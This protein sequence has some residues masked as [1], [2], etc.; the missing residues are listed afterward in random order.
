MTRTSRTV[1][2]L[3][4]LATALSVVAP[5]AW[6][7]DYWEELAWQVRPLVLVDG[8]GSADDWA[9]R[10][11]AARCAM[12]ERRIHWL[13]IGAD[14][15]VWRR[16]GGTDEAQ[17][18]RTRLDESAAGDVR[19]QVGWSAGDKTALVLFGLDGQE[20]YRGRPDSLETIWSLIDRMPMRRA[21]MAREPD[22]CAD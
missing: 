14:G 21:E 1:P 8:D 22:D 18:E 11:L 4:V 19:D 12:A 10:L 9:E 17:V 5:S 20:K 6:A 16:F 7:G 2:L 13:T 15:R 3:A